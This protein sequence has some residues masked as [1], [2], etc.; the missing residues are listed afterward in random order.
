MSKEIDKIKIKNSLFQ[1]L[2]EAIKSRENKTFKFKIIEEKVNANLNI[3]FMSI[4]SQNEISNRFIRD[5]DRSNLKNSNISF[6]ASDVSFTLLD[7]IPYFHIKKF[8]IITNENISYYNFEQIKFYDSI[9]KIDRENSDLCFIILKA[10]EIFKSLVDNSFILEDIKGKTINIE[11]NDY[12]FEHGKIYVFKGYLYNNNNNLLEKTLISSIEEYSSYRDKIYELKE[13]NKMQVGVL[14]NFKAK[15]IT[16]KIKDSLLIIEDELGKKYKVNINFNLLKKI[17]LS[18]ECTFLNF[19]KIKN[20][21]FNF[22]NL[23]NIE[24]KEEETFIEFNFIN[25]KDNK[26]RFYNNIKIDDNLYEIDKKTI[27][28]KINELS[29]KNLFNKKIFFVRIEKEKITDSLEYSYE[30]NRGKTNHIE[31]F[32][33][34]GGFFYELYIKSIQKE[35]LP[36]QIS[37]TI[38]DKILNLNSPDRL[39]NEFQERFIL[40][41]VPQQNINTIFNSCDKTIDSK[42]GKYLILIKDKKYIKD[43]KKEKD[44]III[45]FIKE[46]NDIIKKDF[47]INYNISNEMKKFYQNY[48]DNNNLI[49]IFC[50]KNSKFLDLVIKDKKINSQIMQLLNIMFD[51]FNKYNFSNSKKEYN[52]IKYLSF[53]FI[54][55]YLYKAKDFGY[56]YISNFKL[57]LESIIKLDYIDRIK[58]LIEFI[59]NLYENLFKEKYVIINKKLKKKCIGPINDFFVLINLED[60]TIINKYGYIKLAFDKLYKIIDELYEDCALFKII[61]QINSLIYKNALNNKNIYSGSILNLNDIKLE[62]IQNLNRFLIISRKDRKYLENYAFFRDISLTITINIKSLLPDFLD[63]DNC[64]LNNLSTVILFFLIHEALG[65]KKKNINKENIDT[66]REN[67]GTYFEELSLETSN[68]GL[69]LE[70]IIFGK[71]F[72]PKY[73]IK[74]KNPQIFLNEKLYLEKNFENLHKLYSEL[75]NLD[76]ND[77]TEEEKEEYDE[78]NEDYPILYHDLLAK[79]GNLNEKQNKQNKDNLEYQLFLLMHEDKK[80]KYNLENL[81]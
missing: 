39:S 78:D 17:S 33:G 38:N 68:S 32:L 14:V 60:D 54:C 6:Q 25:Y 71:V 42:S 46:E 26:N 64:N 20:N 79:Y 66:S 59:I 53:I 10:R 55:N 2:Y 23:S 15:I 37:I 44:K 12:N 40:A 3:K 81:K 58:V 19:I 67:Y 65:H 61:Q 13:L 1:E 29:K 69:I 70:D 74:N 21:E 51:G 27:K 56:I 18:Q 5:L 47:M 75:D 7:R 52:N 9:D 63:N 24:S 34:N 72:E 45:K 41:N 22:T 49:N 43:I 77:I 57:L 48:I 28:I 31:G 4:K 30:L 11:E 8:D 16:F 36:K 73:L 35:D 50:N 62:L 80:K 76:L